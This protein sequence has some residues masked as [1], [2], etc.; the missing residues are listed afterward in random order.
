MSE[1][2]RLRSDLQAKKFEKMEIEYEMQPKLKS[3]KEA[4]ASSWRSFGEIN[5]SL[6]Y[7][8]AKDLKSLREKWDGI[9]SDIQKIE[10]EL[11]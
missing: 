6:I 4:L 7:D 5:F 2:Q 3:L 9:V 10:K 11:Q 8:L 1:I